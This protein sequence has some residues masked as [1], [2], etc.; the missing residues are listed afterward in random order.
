MPRAARLFALHAAL[1][2][3]ALHTAADLAA[4]LGVTQ[5]T[6]YRDMATLAT[7]GIPVEG[8]RG[9]GYR[10]PRIVAL[11][12]LTLTEAEA[13]ALTLGI[14]ILAETTDPDLHAA[15]TSLAAK[16]DAAL[17]EH[18]PAPEW[19]TAHRAG[20]SAARGLSHV[21]VLRG[22]IRSRQKLRLTHDGAAMTVRP[23]ALENWSRH[24]VLTCWNETTKDHARLR[25][26]LIEAAEALPELFADEPGKRLSDAP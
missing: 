17:P 14:L 24:W 22:A 9:T 7:S 19:L 6:I 16:L 11:P 5:R 12:P 25:L 23:L 4:R 21:P 1:R 20:A 2:D 13:D 26:D 8:T 10:L 15:A 18:A 3:G